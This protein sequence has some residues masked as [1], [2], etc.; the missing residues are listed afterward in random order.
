M[1][2]YFHVHVYIGNIYIYAI[3]TQLYPYS[4]TLSP[5]LFT[6]TNQPGTYT[7]LPLRQPVVAYQYTYAR[8]TAY[9][10]LLRVP[11][12][13]IWWLTYAIPFTPSYTGHLANQLSL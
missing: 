5:I 11:F 6:Y 12:T 2:I 3:Y 10:Q 9:L 1:Y 4:Y 7:Y 8:I 13:C